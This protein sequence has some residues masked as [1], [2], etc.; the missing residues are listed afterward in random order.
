MTNVQPLRLSD[1]AFIKRVREIA[2]D[3]NRVFLTGHAKGRMRKRKV[4]RMQVIECL[5]K[6]AI[7]EP[8]HLN[9][10]GDWQA[11][12]THQNAGDQVKVAVSIERQE[13]GDLAVVVTVMN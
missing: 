6:G 4:T 7:S 1:P 13:D 10:Y 3:S 8:A 12:L 11:T 2:A 5:R 9:I